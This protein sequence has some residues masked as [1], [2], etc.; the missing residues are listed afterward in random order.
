LYKDFAVGNVYEHHPGRT[1]ALHD[2]AWFTLLAI[3]T[4]LLHF[5]KEHAE[6]NESEKPLICSPLTLAILARMSMS[7][8][9]EK[10]SA[11]PETNNRLIFKK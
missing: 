4:H 11:H 2:N 9:S 1:V 5:A 10:A 3:N 8:V 6:G 7:N